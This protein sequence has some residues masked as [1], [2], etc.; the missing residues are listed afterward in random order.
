MN[1]FHT[2]YHRYAIYDIGCKLGY[3][4]TLVNP[5]LKNINLTIFFNEYKLSDVFLYFIFCYIYLWVLT[6]QKPMRINAKKSLASFKIMKGELLGL[7]VCLRKYQAFIFLNSFVNEAI[8]LLSDKNPEFE[9]FIKKQTN[10]TLGFPS[11]PNFSCISTLINLSKLY[12][13][14]H[15][16]FG[17]S[18]TFKNPSKYLNLW[19]SAHHIPLI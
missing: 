14:V 2:L 6:G 4:N 8:P 19:I 10:Y 5:V 13:S 18:I 12:Y 9:G 11:L 3:K 7:S 15:P 1:N 17:I 16:G